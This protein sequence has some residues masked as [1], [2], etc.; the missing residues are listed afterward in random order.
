MLIRLIGDSKLSLCAL[1]WTVILRRVYSHGLQERE[2]LYIYTECLLPFGTYIYLLNHQ[3]KKY[4]AH[5]L[6]F[7][8]LHT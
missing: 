5:D 7:W 8:K 6:L 4:M 1:Q 3:E 2:P